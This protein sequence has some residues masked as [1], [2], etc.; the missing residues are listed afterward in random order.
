[1]RPE[2]NGAELQEYQTKLQAWLDN[3]YWMERVL[4][5]VEEV[6]TLPQFKLDSPRAEQQVVDG[7]VVLLKGT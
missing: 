6:D 5:P 2:G 4:V 1:M 7:L 3:D